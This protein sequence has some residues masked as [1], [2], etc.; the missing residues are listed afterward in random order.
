M[1]FH[2]FLLLLH[3]KMWFLLIC[4][5]CNG[6]AQKQ[7]TFMLKLCKQQ[8][9]IRICVRILASIYDYV[10]D[11]CQKPPCAEFVQCTNFPR[12]HRTPNA[13]NNKIYDIIIPW[14]PWTDSATSQQKIIPT[15]VLVE[16]A[17]YRFINIL[18]HTAIYMSRFYFDW[19]SNIANALQFKVNLVG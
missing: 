14:F 18:M 2:H 11:S 1:Q 6:K 7:C 13:C 8:R 15:C 12:T 9:S 16:H 5:W 4:D 3:H 17:L 19:M 10:Y